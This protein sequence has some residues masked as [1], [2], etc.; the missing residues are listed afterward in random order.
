MESAR[1]RR[2]PRLALGALG[3][4]ALGVAGWFAWSTAGSSRPLRL[5]SGAGGPVVVEVRNASNKPGIAR[6]VTRLLQQRG[7]DVIYFGTA[8]SLLDSTTVLVRRGELSRG[9]EIA[10]LLG[11]ARVKSAPDTLLRVDATVL[12]GGDFKWPKDRFPL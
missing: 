12:I 7:I 11:Q 2:F 9:L 3:G 10:R 1:S 5:V 8:A 6:L 4:L